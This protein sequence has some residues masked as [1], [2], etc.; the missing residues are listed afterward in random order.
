MGFSSQGPTDS[1]AA[2]SAFSLRL[3]V[4]KIPAVLWTAD[5]N[6]CLTSVTGAALAAMNVRPEDYLGV[7]LIDFSAQL[8]PDTTPLVAHR[9]ALRGKGSTFDIEILGREL[10]AHVEP[11][12][13]PKRNIVGVIGVALDNTDRRVAERALRLSEQSYRS[14]IEGAPYGICRSTVDGQ[15]LQVNRAMAEML[16]YESETELL[17]R[18]LR[19]EIFNELINYDEFLAQLR[20]RGSCQGFE[21]TWQCH[22]GKIILV[23]LGGWSVLDAASEISYLEILAENV[24]ERKQLENQFRQAQKMQAIGQL[25]GGVAHDFNNLLTVVEGQVEMMLSEVP[26]GD[27]LRHRLEAVE[28]AAHLA[29][30]LTRRLLAFSRMQVFQSKV[31]DLNV[32]IAGMSQMLARLIGENIEMTFLPGAD[33]GR[34]KADPSQIEQVLMNLVVNARDAMPD[35]GRLTIETHNARLDRTFVRQQAIVERGDYVLL[36]VSDTGRGMDGETQARVFE[37]FFT[38]KQHGQGTGLGLSMVYGVVKQSGGYIWVYSEPGRGAAFKIYLPRVADRADHTATVVSVS[39]PR[40]EETILFAEDEEGVREIVTG[41]LESQGYQVLAAAD[42]V[43]AMQIAK[44][45]K[46]EID[47]L[48]TDIVMPKKGG[49]ELAEDLCKILPNLKVL[50][51]SGYT[52]GFVVDNSILE[53]GAAFVQK[54]FSMQSLANKIREVLDGPSATPIHPE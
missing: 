1:R 35:G 12:R 23:R 5:M 34:V 42:G 3:L 11:L 49:R 48:L 44:S 19:A 36:V 38:T 17:L 22:G 39:S 9:R 54:P 15:L 40:G 7:S 46:S 27:R 20:D 31:L 32:V 37:P 50:F 43:C 18:S 28:K 4:E 52:G 26:P 21:C 53:S 2:L 10:Q 24:T 25:A 29:S 51:I 45:H 47:L 30:T 14:L 8:G 41:F 6:L 13:G 16:S 33:L